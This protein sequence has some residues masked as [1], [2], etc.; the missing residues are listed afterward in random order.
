M[1]SRRSCSG[2][3]MCLAVLY[4]CF[5]GL[6]AESSLESLLHISSR[7]CLGRGALRVS[8]KIL[9]AW[10]MLIRPPCMLEQCLDWR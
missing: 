3:S 10:K 6:I 1:V 5:F 4:E 7:I 8:F 9:S 2:A